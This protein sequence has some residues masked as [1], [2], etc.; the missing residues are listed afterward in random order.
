MALT[1]QEK[2]QFEELGYFIREA[3]L[4]AEDINRV[5]R[6]IDVFA[7]NER[8][9]DGTGIYKYEYLAGLI[10]EPRTL[11]ITAEL[12][13]EN[14]YVFQKSHAALHR[15]G[16]PAIHWH[17]DYE[18]I[19]QTNR[20]HLQLHVL[21]YLNGLDGTVGDLILWPGS[22][23]SV[24]ARNALKFA[25]TADLP[26]CIVLDRLA[27]GSAV[28]VHSALVHGR[29]EKPGGENFKRYF[30]DISYMER[31]VKWPSYGREEWRDML[32]QLD[33]RFGAEH[34]TLF[35]QDSFFEIAD[36]IQRMDGFSGSMAM[37]LPAGSGQNLQRSGQIPIIQ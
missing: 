33:R 4:S 25:G 6:D 14:G 11:A 30:I 18:Q 2:E 32:E 16:Q 9:F 35:S 28:F 12:M 29:R 15:A 5:S 34:P 1:I 36:A 23:K 24:L 13:G 7:E 19:P 3:L 31:G 22:H 17:H 8:K 26:G 10:V 27:P 20:N 21:H 37:E